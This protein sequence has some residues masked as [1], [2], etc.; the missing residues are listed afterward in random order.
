MTIQGNNS[1]QADVSAA[2]FLTLLAQ[3]PQALLIF[4][5]G[6]RAIQ[7]GYHVTEVKA[8]Q[9]SSL[10]CGANPESWSETIVQLLDVSGDGPHMSASK[11]AGIMQKVA[12]RMTLDPAASL[13]FEISDGLAPMQIYR[14]AT[15]EFEN[16]A[17][18][19]ALTA[20]PAECKPLQASR[21]Q[22]QANA[23]CTPGTKGSGCC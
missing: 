12:S 16:G 9:F 18:H 7:A 19:V 13:I 23:C 22:A 1:F 5:Y 11:F 17:V 10:D 15:A 2:S 21:H 14:V 6:G 3:H 8:G 4:S 20:K